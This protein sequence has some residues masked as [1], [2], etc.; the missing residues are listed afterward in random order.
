MTVDIADSAVSTGTAGSVFDNDG[1]L[2]R[3]SNLAVTEVDAATLVATANG[4]NSFL[5]ES[6][7]SECAFDSVTSASTTGAQSV[8][9]VEVTRMR[10]IDDAFVVEDAGSMLTVTGLSMGNNDINDGSRWTAVSAKRSATATVSGLTI[11][12]NAGLE[13]GVS[14]VG[15]GSTL[16]VRDSFVLDN[17]GTVRALSRLL[18][19]GLQKAVG[20]V[21]VSMS[22]LLLYAHPRKPIPLFF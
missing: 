20:N 9:D 21:E 10:R 22:S 2:L 11:S 19:F 6:S 4:G 3:I 12:T 13:F 15:S 8:M 7:V 16:T 5:S 14:A 17:A 1:G 18:L